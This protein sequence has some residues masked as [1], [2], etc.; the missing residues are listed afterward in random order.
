[1]VLIYRRE[2]ARCPFSIFPEKSML[3]VR[4]TEFEVVSASIP[5]G[6]RAVSESQG[7]VS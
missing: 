7:E 1:M 4:N 3:L 2:F 5:A 6:L